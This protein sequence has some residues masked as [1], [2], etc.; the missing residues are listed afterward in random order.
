[1][2]KLLLA[3][4][5]HLS[6]A[7]KDYS[8]SV[9]DEILEL[10]KG[11]DALLL[12]G[13]TFNDFGDLK[14]LKDIFSEKVQG[15]GKDVYLL[16]GNHEALKSNGMPLSK[17]KFPAN[18]IVIEEKGIFA[19]EGLDIV[20]LAY[21]EKCNMDSDFIKEIECL[22]A[23]NRIFI[24]H[25][26]VEGTSWIMESGEEKAAIPI[27]ALK[28]ARPDLAVIGHI[29]KQMQLKIAGLD[30]IYTGSARVW[31]KSK[32]ELGARRCL[33]LDIG[34]N[35]MQKAFVPIKSAGEY[36]VYE[37]DLQDID[38]TLQ[39]DSAEWGER[40]VIDVNLY[41]IIEDESQLEE[42]KESIKRAYSKLVRE[43]NVNNGEAVLLDNARGEKVIRDFMEIADECLQGA[44]SEEEAEI[45]ELAKRL[46]IQKIAQALASKKK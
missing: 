23:Q 20:A 46:G 22:K 42:K 26:V 7:E 39:R 6:S 41:G 11:C 45:A 24:G 34:E 2:P 14:A 36:R 5:L 10:A 1:M 33:S 19:L 13:D 32:A 31:R 30:V 35:G 43:I 44:K 16:K 21:S 15:F 40:D 9:L 37:R 28:A 38:A 29:H 18:V 27:D 8:L 25:G 3:S 17:L 12:L 4:D